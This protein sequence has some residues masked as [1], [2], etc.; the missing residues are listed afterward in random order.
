ML[1]RLASIKPFTLTT[2]TIMGI[3][4]KNMKNSI[5]SK[6]YPKCKTVRGAQET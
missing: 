2:V 6:N 1:K 5:K 3:Q 4:D